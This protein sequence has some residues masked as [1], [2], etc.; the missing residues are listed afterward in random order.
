MHST[1]FK[2]NEERQFTPKPCD[3]ND[4]KKKSGTDEETEQHSTNSHL[5]YKS[6]DSIDS[7]DTSTKTISADNG[8]VNADNGAIVNTGHTAEDFAKEASDNFNTIQNANVCFN[9]V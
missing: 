6:S 2:Q 1:W 4:M 3:F 5:S 7:D 8:A 9:L